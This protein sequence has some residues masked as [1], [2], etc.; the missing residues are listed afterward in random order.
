M[1]ERG[2][3]ERLVRASA[4]L[5]D[6]LAAVRMSGLP[7][8]M[9]GAGVLRDLVWGELHAGFDPGRVRDVD[10]AYFDPSDLRAERDA[11]AEERLR[12]LLPVVPWEAKNQAAVHTWYACR[13]GGVPYT[14]V[15]STCEA[16]SRWPETATSVAVRLDSA[17]RLEVC[18]PVGLDDLLG[19]VWRRNPRQVSLDESLRRL[20]RHRVA[21]RWPRVRVI[22][23][24]DE[25]G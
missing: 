1:T 25:A 7:D 17:G 11:A 5:M 6:V 15:G 19:G 13:F 22:P 16:V 2:E 12:Q 24:G 23:P 21:E 20:R 4:W 18:A 9:V 10:V 3:L 8:A 14:P